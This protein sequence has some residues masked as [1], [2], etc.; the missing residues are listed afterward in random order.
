MVSTMRSSIYGVASDLILS[1]DEP[2]SQWAVEYARKN[3]RQ[4]FPPPAPTWVATSLELIE[5]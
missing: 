1:G 4:R 3:G 2:A 5:A